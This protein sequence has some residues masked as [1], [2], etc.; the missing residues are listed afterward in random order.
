LPMSTVS[1]QEI[2]TATELVWLDPKTLVRNPANVRGDLRTLDELAGSIAESGIVEP[3]VVVP[4]ED[5]HRILAGHRRAAA[6]VMAEL[7]VVPC[8]VRADLAEAESDQVA[9]ALIENVQRD[10]LT[11]LEEAH[12]YA[13][14]SVFLHWSPG[15]I[16]QAT[17][18]DE[19]S[20][21]RG[22]EATGLAEE[23]QPAAI[24]GQ[25]SLEGTARIASFVDDPETYATLVKIAGARP[26]R[27][28]PVRTERERDVAAALPRSMSAWR[29]R[30][31]PL[32][33]APAP[34][35]RL[36]VTH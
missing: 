12:A 10:D 14:P 35:R 34:R 36:R 20:V 25:L 16:A 22:I 18:R 1:S 9:L 8:W 13:Q 11:A 27:Q 31:Y 15:R 17:G 21:R 6:A 23:L 2:N 29:S 5:G 33:S 32:L 28:A 30:A 24:A 26:I 19:R 4:L 7:D 3:L